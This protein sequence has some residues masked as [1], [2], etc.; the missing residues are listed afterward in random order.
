MSPRTVGILGGMGPEA[1]VLL[2]QKVIAAVPAQ[3][4]AGH[5]RLIVDQNPQLPS[6]IAWLLEGGGEDPAPVTAFDTLDVLVDQIVAFSLG[7]T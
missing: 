7:R 1:K 6:R 3:D 5:V 2:M 4:D